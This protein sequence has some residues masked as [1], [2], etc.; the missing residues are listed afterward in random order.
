[1]IQYSIS[2]A[3]L[4]FFLLVL[5]RVTCFIQAAPFFGMNQVPQ[6]AKITLGVFLSYLI[7]YS[8]MPHEQIIYETVLQYSTIVLREAVVGLTIGWA[9]N[10]CSSIVFFAGR[11]VDMEIG[12]SMANAIDPTTRENATLTG[13][14][15][16]YTVMLILMVSGM[17]RYL[18]TAFVE[19]YQL[20]PVN[21]ARIEYGS[22]VDALSKYLSNYVNLGFRI[23][24]PIFC[25]IMIT[26][27]VLGILAKVA[28]QMNMFAVGMQIKILIG[29]SVMLMTT[30]ML[31]YISDF[32]YS[33]MK[34]MIV[35]VVE[36]FMT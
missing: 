19:S 20:I 32:I 3:E 1:M 28:P 35:S 36:A 27:V 8:T 16:Q 34:V 7:Y 22:I 30:A 26:N 4:E 24:L 6:Q 25:V 10:I 33:Q 14:Y 17:H 12:L 5:V 9:A 11:M 23:C 13:F 2:I 15:Y 21:R 18:I 31:P 29:F